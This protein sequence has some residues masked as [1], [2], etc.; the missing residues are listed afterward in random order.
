MFVYSAPHFPHFAQSCPMKLQP[1]FL[2][3]TTKHERKG[4]VVK[5]G[6]KVQKILQPLH[7]S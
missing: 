5:R 6:E 3:V 4:R 7:D 1:R 2:L